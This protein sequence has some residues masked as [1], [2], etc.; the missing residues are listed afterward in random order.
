VPRLSAIRWVALVPLAGLLLV[1]F[2]VETLPAD[3]GRETAPGDVH[4]VTPRATT[5]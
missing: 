1:P 3:A 5:V 4:R 2:I